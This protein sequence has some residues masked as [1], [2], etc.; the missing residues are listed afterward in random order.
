[1]G[2]NRQRS[3][4]FRFAFLAFLVWLAWSS[5]ARLNAQTTYTSSPGQTSIFGYYDPNAPVPSKA[6]VPNNPASTYTLPFLP[7][8]T[9]SQYLAQKAAIA[10]FSQ[11][12]FTSSTAVEV[13]PPPRAPT[14]PSPIVSTPTISWPGLQDTGYQPPSP[15]FAVG[16]SDALMVINSNIAQFTKSGTMVKSTALQDWFANVL[17]TT[18]PSG[19]LLFDPWIVYDQLHGRFLFLA[20][21]TPAIE[22]DRTVSY[23]LL[24]VSN[25]ATYASG[26]KNWAMKS[27]V[28]GT[29]NTQHWGDSWRLGFDD[30]AIY[31]SG[32]MYDV[33]GIFQYAKIR[34]LKKSDVYNPATTT[35][36]YQEFGSATSM[37]LNGDCTVADSLIPIRLRGTPT[38]TAAALF[39]NALGGKAGPSCP[40]GFQPPASGTYLT[41]WKIAD[42]LAATLTLTET[43]VGGLLSYTVPAPAPQLGTIATLDSGDTRVLKAIYRSGFLYTAR[44]TGY[45]D[46]ATTVTYD[47]INTSTMMLASQARLVNT[48]AFYPAFDVPA[49]TPLGTQFATANLTT[50]TTTSATGTLTYPG[51]SNN[52]QAGQGY[53]DVTFGGLNRWGDYFGGT[54]DPVSGGLWTSGEYALVPAAGNYGQWGTWAGY[55]PWLTVQAFTDVPSSSPYSDFINV[56]SAW[57]ITSGC[58]TA[59]FCPTNM[60]TRDQMAVLIVRSMLGSSTFTFTA[61]PYY[62]DVPASSPFFPYIQKL[63]DLG[64]THGCTATT[65][66]PSGVVNRQDAAVLLVRG[67]LESLFGDT[68]T[69]PTAPFFTDVPATLPQFPYVQK[70]Y[71]LGLTAGCSPTQFCPNDTLTRQQVAVFL[72]RAFL[73]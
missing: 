53:F 25:G 15:D 51:L 6:P 66:C 59:S 64:I 39:V 9:M 45:T 60:V 11:S 18:C 29:V 17:A 50:G 68:F 56:L 13:S 48:N 71:E 70:M 5:D 24:S 38:A 28:D 35:L 44:D 27:S 54:V 37:L 43:T 57:Q 52:L 36:P 22:S 61:T 30:E 31:L 14:I 4:G 26:W 34:V 23:L 46:Q 41:V 33:S 3:N 19:C 47:V 69:Y 72:T 62:T 16:P 20:G 63:T 32:N 55:Y 7:A 58:A 1:M 49:T 65:Y 2:T 21:A 10:K 42:P 67:K 40:S 12:N 73:N 8:A